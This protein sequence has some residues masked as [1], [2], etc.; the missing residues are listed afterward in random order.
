MMSL[1]ACARRGLSESELLEL[2]NIKA[3][4]VWSPLYLE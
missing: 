1:L 3:R 2:L 4:I